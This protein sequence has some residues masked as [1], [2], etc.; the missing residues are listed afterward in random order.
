MRD[1]ERIEKARDGLSVVALFSSGTVLLLGAA[2]ALFVPGLCD[3]SCEADWP[4]VA[5]LAPPLFAAG[6]GLLAAAIHLTLPG[7]SSVAVGRVREP[8]APRRSLAVAFRMGAALQAMFGVAF[9][10]SETGVI[11]GNVAW[12]AFWLVALAGWGGWAIRLLRRV[13]RWG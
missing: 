1:I 10:L 9:V 2:I 8:H 6:A 7:E 3:G 13:Q 11:S 12:A 5:A 4:L